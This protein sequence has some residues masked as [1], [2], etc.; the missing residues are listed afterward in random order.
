MGCLDDWAKKFGISSLR[1]RIENPIFSA[2]MKCGIQDLR[3]VA[4]PLN[5][6]AAGNRFFSPIWTSH[7]VVFPTGGHL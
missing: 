1:K 7:M 2:E 3:L 4:Y 6:T 5:Y